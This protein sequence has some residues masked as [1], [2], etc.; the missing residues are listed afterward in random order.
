MARV[1]LRIANGRW[2]LDLDRLLEAMTPDT[3]MVII[4]SPNNPTG[5]TIEEDE[6]DA[7]LAH[8]RKHGIW[9][10]ADEVY[11]RLVYDPAR[12]SAPSFLRRYEEGDRIISTNSF[13]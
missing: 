2:A 6:V 5:W 12:R 10:L 11:E 4:N 9:V 8:A 7:V 13:S 3:R 1:P